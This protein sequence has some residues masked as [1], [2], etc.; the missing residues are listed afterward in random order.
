MSKKRKRY[1]SAF[2]AKVAIEAIRDESTTAELA[3]KYE[4]HPTMISG[5]KRALLGPLRLRY[6]IGVRNQKSNQMFRLKNYIVILVSL[7]GGT[8]FFCLEIDMP[9]ISGYPV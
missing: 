6:L 3:K 2:K 5:W 4:V 9:V 7:K 1:S 8:G